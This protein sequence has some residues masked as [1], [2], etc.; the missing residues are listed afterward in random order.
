MEALATE[1]TYF[2]TRTPQSDGQ[3]FVHSEYCAVLPQASELAEVGT[4]GDGA[5]ALARAREKQDPVN[6]CAMCMPEHH[7]PDRAG[8][9]HEHDTRE[10]AEGALRESDGD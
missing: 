4:Y 1:K 7:V 10:D 6:A 5:E 2:V 9:A 8:G 3:H